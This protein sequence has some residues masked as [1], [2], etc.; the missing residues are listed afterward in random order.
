M[1]WGALG[2]AIAIAIFL[3]NFNSDQTSMSAQNSYVADE[4]KKRKKVPYSPEQSHN[5]KANYTD[6]VL[7]TTDYLDYERHKDIRNRWIVALNRYGLD[8][9][10]INNEAIV[11]LLAKEATMLK[12]LERI[13]SEI[14]G[15]EPGPEIARM[16]EL[17]EKYRQQLIGIIGS[18]DK[19]KA[20]LTFKANYFEKAMQQPLH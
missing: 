7:Y 16:R 9:L 2:L 15:K 14:D 6:N 11:K 17:E 12:Q 18:E 5:F 8:K 20:F 1:K 10:D 19:L 13:K 3:W 4:I